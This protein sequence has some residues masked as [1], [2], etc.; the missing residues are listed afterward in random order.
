MSR[1]FVVAVLALLWTAIAA[2]GD[3][4][5]GRTINLN[6]PGALEALQYANP[7]HYEKVRQIMEGLLQQPDADVPRWI[8]TT[9]DAREVRYAPIVLTSDPPKKRLSFALDDTRYEAVVTLTNVR[10]AIV[11]AK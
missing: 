4:T 10:G 5:A 1:P 3:V 8:Q 7:T 2:T 6:E 11:P 9:F